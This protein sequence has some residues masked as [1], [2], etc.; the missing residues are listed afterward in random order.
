MKLRILNNEQRDDFI[1][2]VQDVDV[3]VAHRAEFTKITRPRS[4]NQ[5]AYL[6]LCL[7][8]AEEQ[9]GTDK[10]WYYRYY[11]EKFPTLGIF[12]IFGMDRVVTLTSS[13][14]NTKQMTR[15]LDA[16]RLDLSENGIHT[17]DADDRR[18]EEIFHD[19]QKCGIL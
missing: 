9:T 2:K 10:N 11:L 16:V 8:I 17:P 18:L 6:W 5:N 15:F 13:G 1:Q 4:L 3:K 14:F 19:M 12:E 7:A